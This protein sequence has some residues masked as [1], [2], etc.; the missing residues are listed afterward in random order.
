MNIYNNILN[1]YFDY[2]GPAM[3]NTMKKIV[4]TLRNN[5]KA[6]DIKLGYMTGDYDLETSTDKCLNILPSL[7][8]NRYIVKESII[9]F[10]H[11]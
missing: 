2:K 6:I 10:L 11:T 1:C 7:N 5:D 9:R 8:A 4:N 3:T